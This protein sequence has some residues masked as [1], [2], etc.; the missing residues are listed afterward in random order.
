MVT[1]DNAVLAR[2]KSHG[3][4]FEILVDCNL[5]I[6]LKEGKEVNMHDVLAVPAVFSDSKKGDRASPV[7]LKQV[8]GTDD[9]IEAAKQIIK[10]GEVQ[11]TAEYRAQLREN[12]KKQIISYIQRNAVDPKTNI[13]HPLYRIQSALEEAGFRFDEHKSVE[14]QVNEALKV[15]RPIIPIKFVKKEIAVK[16]PSQYSGKAQSALHG[17]GKILKSEWQHDGSWVAVFEI[18]GGLEN[19][20]YDKLNAFTHGDNETKLL[21]T[22]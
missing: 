14:E 13:P 2:Y 20:F 22:I 17:F 5:A 21:K 7:Q 18:P 15:L 8:F 11:V 12:K 10:K 4:N 16:V 1:V 6:A 9:E 3:A 19:E